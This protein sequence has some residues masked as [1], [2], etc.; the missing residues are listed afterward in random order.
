LG[1]EAFLSQILLHGF[2]QADPHPGNIFVLDNEHIA[3]ID[4]EKLVI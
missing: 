4:F 2:F 3:F 1:T